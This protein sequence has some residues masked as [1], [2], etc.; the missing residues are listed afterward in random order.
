MNIPIGSAIKHFRKEQKLTQEKLGGKIGVSGKT[1]GAYENHVN[2]PDLDIL[3]ALS[4]CFGITLTELIQKT[5]GMMD[6]KK[7]NFIIEYLDCVE[8]E[9][10]NQAVN[11]VY[12]LFPKDTALK[13]IDHIN[14]IEGEG[15]ARYDEERDVFFV[16]DQRDEEWEEYEGY[17]IVSDGKEIQ[18]YPICSNH[19]LWEEAE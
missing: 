4:T 9:G 2:E 17:P 11:G 19:W 15:N 12:P 7:T 14:Q 6:M 5:E 8:Y 10:F 18:V 13:I 16:I 3:M 1:I